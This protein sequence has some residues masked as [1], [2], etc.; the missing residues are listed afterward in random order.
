ML[1]F[2]NL[3]L[4]FYDLV[5]PCV[6][7]KICWWCI[8]IIV[9]RVCLDTIVRLLPDNLVVT[10][11][12]CGNDLCGHNCG[13]ILPIKAPSMLGASC[14]GLSFYCD[15]CFGACCLHSPHWAIQ[16]SYICILGACTDLYS[17]L[18]GWK[19][20]KRWSMV[21][22]NCCDNQCFWASWIYSKSI[23]QSISNVSWT[24]AHF[25][26]DQI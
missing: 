26:F 4:S 16:F 6:G 15:Y 17:M 3:L 18:V 20:C 1:I 8:V 13:C 25:C 2:F 9:W 10:S 14:I 11:S 21:C 24:G 12:S 22:L 23:I 7:H 19:F 5:L